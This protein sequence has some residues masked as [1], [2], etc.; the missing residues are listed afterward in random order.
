MKNA[1][2]A[3]DLALHIRK[4]PGMYLGSLSMRSILQ[5]LKG[6]IDVVTQG[7]TDPVVKMILLSDKQFQVSFYGVKVNGLVKV[8]NDVLLNGKSDEIVFEPLTFLFFGDPV[9]ITIRDGNRKLVYTGVK[10]TVTQSS[11]ITTQDT[12]E[13]VILD[14]TKDEEVLPDLNLMYELLNPPLRRYA[15]LRPQCRIITEDQTGVEFQRNVFHYPSGLLHRMDELLQQMPGKGRFKTGI[16]TEIGGYHYQI[17]ISF[18]NETIGTPFIRTYA[19]LRATRYGGSL[20]DGILDGIRDVFKWLADRAVAWPEV[21]HGL[22]MLALVDG[23]DF[24]FTG[25]TREE[26]D[27]PVI[28]K[29]V[30]K[31]VGEELQKYFSANVEAAEAVRASL[32]DRLHQERD[33]Q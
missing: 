17:A 8:L 12:D 7:A 20:H 5:M 2:F 31:L 3:R 21:K 25:A 4:R 15:E 11:E 33:S 6:T 14:F 19:G 23:P 18:G 10:G 22:I 16:S 27:M 32:S 9:I 24:S 26:L 13:D 30:R 28:K 29:E 1:D